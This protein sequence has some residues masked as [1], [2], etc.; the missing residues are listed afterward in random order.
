MAAFMHNDIIPSAAPA[1]SGKIH[2]EIAVLELVAVSNSALVFHAQM[3]SFNQFI[4]VF[5]ERIRTKP[6][7]KTFQHEFHITAELCFRIF[8]IVIKYPVVAIKLAF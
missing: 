3:R 4:T 7:L 8:K 1:T 2:A 5:I 6:M